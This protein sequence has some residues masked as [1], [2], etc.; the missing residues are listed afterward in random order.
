MI[1]RCIDGDGTTEYLGTSC[2]SDP[3]MADGYLMVFDIHA[4]RVILV[5]PR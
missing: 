4:T 3:N 5:V 1:N 2:W